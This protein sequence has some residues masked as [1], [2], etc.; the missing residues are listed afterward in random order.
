MHDMNNVEL[1][2]PKSL[3][4]SA[5]TLSYIECD[6][7]VPHNLQP[8]LALNPLSRHQAIV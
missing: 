1:S 3:Q 4:T 6:L 5:G 8:T 7:F 2:F